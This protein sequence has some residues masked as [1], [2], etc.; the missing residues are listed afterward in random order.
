MA[1][2]DYDEKTQ[3]S[4]KAEGSVR[5]NRNQASQELG[6]VPLPACPHR[7]CFPPL[8]E[9]GHDTYVLLKLGR[10][11]TEGAHLG[12]SQRCFSLMHSRIPDPQEEAQCSA[13]RI[14]CFHLAYA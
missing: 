10:P 14:L 2:V 11:R 5:Y 8:P 9:T 13:S 6:G 4:H 7:A 1:T 3:E 12:C